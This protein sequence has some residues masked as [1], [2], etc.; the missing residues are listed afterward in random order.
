MNLRTIL[1][2]LAAFFLA[3]VA[4]FSQVAAPAPATPAQG[5]IVRSIEVNY[6]G[7]ATVSK[8][9]IL[10][11]MRTQVGKPY[12]E[13]EVEEDIRSL[14]QTG[15][16]SNVR[17]FGEPQGDGVKVIVVVATKSQVVDVN[18]NG[19]SKFKPSRIRKEITTKPGDTLNEATLESDRQ[20][21]L[22]YYRNHGYSEVDVHVSSQV[23]EKIN[24]AHVVFDVNEGGKMTV[25]T[26]R[27]EGNTS[28]TRKQLL[29]A[30]QPIQ[31]TPQREKVV[32]TQ[33]KTIFNI[34]TAKAGKVD[35]EQLDHDVNSLRDFYQNHGYLDV[36]VQEP[37][38]EH[39]DGKVDVIFPIVEG[40][41][42]HVGT[43]TFIG[44][45]VFTPD[46]LAKGTT[47]KTGSVYSPATARDDIKAVQDLYGSKGY[48][49]FQA[50]AN[51]TPSGDHVM[52]LIYNV[53]EGAQSYVEHI[54]ITGN[55]RTKDK[56]IRR[57][58]A[59]A[60]GDIF[61]TVRVDASR[62][63]LLALEYFG[64]VDAYPVDTL[65]PGRK[66]LN[67]IVEEKRTG[68]FNFGAGFS[69]IDS[70]LGF[71]EITQSNFDLFGWPHFT[72]GGQRFRIR[73][74]YGTERKDFVISLTEPYFLDY[75]LTVNGEI[76]YHEADFVSDVYSERRYGFDINGR[77]PL[78][79]FTTL[80]FGYK[81][82][83]VGITNVDDSASDFI[84]SQEH[85]RLESQVSA[86]INYDSRDNL[87]LTRSGMKLDASAYIDGG[88]LGGDTQ[89]Y[90]LDLEGSKY[91]HLPFDS[92]L[93]I[94]GEVGVVSTWGSGDIVPIWD[95]LYLGGANNLRGYKYR[96]A[97]PKDNKGEP[98]GG[99]TLARAT[100][101]YTYPII[102]KVR[103]AFF[104][105][106]GFVN[107]QSYNFSP[108]KTSTESGGLN[109]DV[110]IGL[111]LDL[112]IGPIR[113]DYGIPLQ[114][115]KFTGSS[116][117]FNFNIG[118]QF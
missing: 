7:P 44:A 70:L 104:Y 89:I 35:S 106:V 9:K 40:P 74:Q 59:V 107:A 19:V 23:D 118:Y 100:I 113:I 50:G 66:D 8:E 79:E 109:Q 3:T 96:F 4:G 64:K 16:I 93:T 115:D 54:N 49:D 102:D 78:T 112:P 24:K 95:A 71:A 76:F 99:N 111:R 56:V 60:P 43:V 91:F 116:G 51:T 21:V 2:A 12:S 13:H 88:F 17:I 61:N 77:K 11:N 14:Y 103:G 52:N 33:K 47:L 75:K 92:I 46:E 117:K 83:D 84:K 39:S 37:R 27:F 80:R 110:G 94:N 28:F 48:V 101:E 108:T 1:P 62:K 90:G 10:A 65:I 86:G 42:Y 87:R 58:V 73:V 97:G 34:L 72:G 53:D 69:S 25:R 26:V 57:E 45:K 38:L 20:K 98:I 5:P 114:H 81:L 30:D 29:K 31:G 18:I 68:S 22:E 41:Q 63:R 32:L 82:E 55:T 105:D 67:V 85:S 15:S 6:A 36:Q